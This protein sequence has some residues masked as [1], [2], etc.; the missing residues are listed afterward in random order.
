MV[1]GDLSSKPVEQL[2]VFI[3]EIITPLLSNKQNTETW[4]EVVQT[5]CKTH[6]KGILNSVHEVCN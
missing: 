2:G 5:D 3:E 4:P 6:L 1:C